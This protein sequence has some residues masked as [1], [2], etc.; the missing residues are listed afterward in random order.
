MNHI[1]ADEVMLRLCSKHRLTLQDVSELQLPQS[2]YQKRTAIFLR[3]LANKGVP[4]LKDFLEVLHE[5]KHYKPH[6]DLA[7]K[8][9][10]KLEQAGI[11]LNEQTTLPMHKH[12][13]SISQCVSGT[14]S[15]YQKSKIRS[16]ST[17]ASTGQ[18]NSSILMDAINS[19]TI[20]KAP[21]KKVG[22]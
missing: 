6:S 1:N 15:T 16:A 17:I 4:A 7:T 5:T 20:T 21:I 18:E 11:R 3:A 19:S 22:H 8:L 14:S 10:Y 9:H 13:G 2:D 12:H